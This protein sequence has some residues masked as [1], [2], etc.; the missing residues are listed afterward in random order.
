MNFQVTARKWRPR[1]FESVVGQSQVT[2]SLKNAITSDRIGQSYLFSGPR[3]VGKT[4]IARILVKALNCERGPTISP[5]ENCIHCRD[6][7][8]NRSLDY[9]EIDGASNRGIDQIREI[10]DS[11]KYISPNNNYRVFVIDEVHMLTI[12]AFNALLKNLEEPPPKVIFVFCT[13]EPHKVPATIRS[14]CQH[15]NFR[16]FPIPIIAEQLKMILEKE[17]IGTSEEALFYIAKAANGSMRDS[18][19]ILDQVIAYGN[20]HV[21]TTAVLDMLGLTSFDVHFEFLKNI[22]SNNVESNKKLFSN[23]YEQGRDMKQFVYELIDRVNALIFIKEGIDDTAVLDIQSKEFT[24]LKT[25]SAN[26][27]LRDI[28]FLGDLLFEFLK[29]LKLSIEVKIT[30][31]LYLLKLHRFR[32]L[33]SPEQLK[34]EMLELSKFLEPDKKSDLSMNVPPSSVATSSS[35][36]STNEKI[37]KETKTSFQISLKP[38]AKFETDKVKTLLKPYLET[39]FKWVAG[40]NSILTLQEKKEHNKEQLNEIKLAVET[41]LKEK[42]GLIVKVNIL[43]AQLNSHQEIVHQTLKTFNGEIMN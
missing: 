5:C 7:A 38:L 21:T 42:T 23:L 8:E 37:E 1:D 32:Q 10:N 40:D 34:A 11:L 3:G 30:I 28:Y 29:E 41:L 19:S 25:L 6:I 35:P 31:D 39:D 2:Q 43:N 4:T 14:R 9:A 24:E 33:I 20:G 27:E 17:K 22:Q 36:L 18:Q 12:E 13:T 15:Y 26:F 16:A